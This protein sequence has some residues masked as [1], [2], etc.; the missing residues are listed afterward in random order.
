MNSWSINS[1]QK[2]SKT[3]GTL[4][5]QLSIDEASNLSPN[6]RSARLLSY[7]IRQHLYVVHY[8]QNY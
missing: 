7:T 6:D 5:L 4:E 1:L 8:I 3:L 2:V